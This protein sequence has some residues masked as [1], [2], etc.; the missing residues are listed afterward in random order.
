MFSKACEYGIRAILY[1]ANESQQ[2]RR[3]GLKSIAKAIDSPEAFTA[4]ILQQLA[5]IGLVNS[6]KGPNGGFEMNQK[7]LDTIYLAQIVKAIDGE[8]IYRA[9]GLGLN[10]CNADKPCPVHHKFAAIRDQLQLML[11]STT[12]L[13]L[14]QGLNSGET[15]I[16]N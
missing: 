2:G 9:C 8:A 4:K 3:A 11:E 15:T 13:E 7:D 12:V 16:K 14:S 10:E 6:V 5:K 1:L